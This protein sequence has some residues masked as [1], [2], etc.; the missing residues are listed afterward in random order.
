MKNKE[1]LIQ[2]IRKINRQ[3]GIF[4]GY[5]SITHVSDDSKQ[6][7]TGPSRNYL[8]GLLSAYELIFGNSEELKELESS[9]VQRRHRIKKLMNYLRKI[10]LEREL[11]KKKSGDVK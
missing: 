11:A 3:L 10:Y 6:I 9:L 2:H 4:E 5:V 8:N 1:K 7:Y